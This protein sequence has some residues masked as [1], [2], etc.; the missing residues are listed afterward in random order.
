MLI[1]KRQRAKINTAVKP[2]KIT[3][4]YLGPGFQKLVKFYSKYFARRRFKV[5]HFLPAYKNFRN[6]HFLTVIHNK[7][8]NK[9]GFAK[10]SRATTWT[11]Y[12]NILL[13]KYGKRK[14]Q[15]E[16]KNKRKISRQLKH[17]IK[18]QTKANQEKPSATLNK[19]DSNA[20]L[21]ILEQSN[22]ES[23]VEQPETSTILAESCTNDETLQNTCSNNAND[24]E[25]A[26]EKSCF[27]DEAIDNIWNLDLQKVAALITDSGTDDKLS[28]TDASKLSESMFNDI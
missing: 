13:T 9:G 24:S 18:P 10:K 25:N 15:K 8:I 1:S 28:E 17:S 22:Q 26:I 2:F 20:S 5:K 3:S 7:F 11:F 4:N 21:P 6:H 16:A 23:I 19:D 12:G 27:D 14:Q